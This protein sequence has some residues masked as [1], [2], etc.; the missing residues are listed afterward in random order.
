MRVL[1]AQTLIEAVFPFLIIKEGG[2]AVFRLHIY[3]SCGES[4]GKAIMLC[5]FGCC[6]C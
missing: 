2:Q 4:T 5:V 1:F 6:R 3:I